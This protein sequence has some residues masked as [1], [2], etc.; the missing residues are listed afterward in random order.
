MKYEWDKEINL[1]RLDRGTPPLDE[2]AQREFANPYMWWQCSIPQSS[3]RTR[4][5]LF[6]RLCVEMVIR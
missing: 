3:T 2:F 1:L 6:P 4:T 5:D